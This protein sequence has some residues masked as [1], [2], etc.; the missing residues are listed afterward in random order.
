M[1]MATSFTR[2]RP[3]TRPCRPPSSAPAP[4]PASTPSH[5]LPVVR[6]LNASWVGKTSMIVFAGGS[7][8]YSL[9]ISA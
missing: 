6:T 1:P 9:V 8:L 2:A 7:V 4:A 3:Q 5:G